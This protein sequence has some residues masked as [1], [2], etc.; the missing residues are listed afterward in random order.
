MLFVFSK[1]TI[2]QNHEKAFTQAERAI[3]IKQCYKHCIKID[4]DALKIF[5]RSRTNETE[6][7]HQIKN[8]QSPLKIY[9]VQKER[10]IEKEIS[11]DIN[12]NWHPKLSRRK[13]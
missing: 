9:R 1:F 2:L 7:R 10:V 4:I 8:S 6:N 5:E 13:N 11:A 12:T 3:G